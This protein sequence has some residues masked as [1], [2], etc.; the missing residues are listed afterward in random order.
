MIVRYLVLVGV[1]LPLTA[2]AAEP[3]LA[4]YAYLPATRADVL[5]RLGRT[6]EAVAAYGEAIDRTSND[7]ERRFLRQ[8]RA[9]LEAPATGSA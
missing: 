7:R 5:R 3:A 4:R 2:L 8:R 9:G 1:C 6:A